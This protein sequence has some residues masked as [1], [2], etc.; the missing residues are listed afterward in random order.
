[1]DEILKM[2]FN[3]LMHKEESI[4]AIKSMSELCTVVWSAEKIVEIFAAINDDENIVYNTADILAIADEAYQE[5][6]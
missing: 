1:M 6:K 2:L 4:E 3:E 5:V